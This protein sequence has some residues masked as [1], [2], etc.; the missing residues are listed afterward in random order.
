[1]FTQLCSRADE[2]TVSQTPQAGEILCFL[3][4]QPGAV[5]LLH[6]PLWGAEISDFT[7]PKHLLRR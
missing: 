4:L 2:I 5:A 7:D 6:F 1:M 3:K